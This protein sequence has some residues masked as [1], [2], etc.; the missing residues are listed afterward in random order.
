MNKL[1]KWFLDLF[2]R[3]WTKVADTSRFEAW[4]SWDGLVIFFDKR[5][6]LK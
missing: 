6:R 5:K 2:K 3:K 4:Q 1:I